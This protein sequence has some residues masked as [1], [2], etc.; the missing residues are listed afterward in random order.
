[1]ASAP[2][3]QDR[4]STPRGGEE[5]PESASRGHDTC[6]LHHGHQHRA[7]LDCTAGSTASSRSLNEVE[8]LDRYH[9][10]LS[11]SV[12]SEK[13]REPPF[14]QNYGVQ[15]PKFGLWILDSEQGCHLVLQ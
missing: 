8:G 14:L 12:Q 2:R 3:Q 1:M 5:E 15:I 13:V 10:R 9:G 4:W 7:T 11:R 6:D